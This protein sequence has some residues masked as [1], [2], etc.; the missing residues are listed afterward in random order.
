[1][2]T[3][4]EVDP[5]VLRD[6]AGGFGGIADGLRGAAPGPALMGASSAMSGL[7]TASACRQVADR[8]GGRAAALG[9]RFAAHGDQLGAAAA[10]YERGDAESA[11]RIEGVGPDAPAPGEEGEPP[12]DGGDYQP[13]TA[14]QLQKIVP[15]MTAQRAQEVVGPLNDAMR[16]GGM[17]TPKRQAAFISQVAVESDRFNTYEEYADG[18]DYE[19][20]TDLGNTQPGDGTRYKGRGAIQVTGRDNYTRMSK[21]L[22]V[23]FVNHPELAAD[24]KYAF[25]TA[26]WYWESRDG[27]AV[28][29]GGDIVKITEMVNGGHNA[30]DVRTGYYDQ[31][32][33]VLGR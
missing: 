26:L 12:S 24:P 20:R 27:N 8:L 7:E 18:S 10:A 6:A 25:K 33:R 11:N 5:S 2:T 16:Q 31:A 32:L 29:D 15:E 28:A 17:N 19:G 14:E 30:L 3:P 21:D 9:D 13:V 23:D 1:M 4:L 22:G